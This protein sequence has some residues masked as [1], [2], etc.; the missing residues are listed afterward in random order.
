MR[1]LRQSAPGEQG[2]RAVSTEPGAGSVWDIR[3]TVTL[4]SDDVPGSLFSADEF[5][6]LCW[7]TGY[8]IIAMTVIQYGFG[9]SGNSGVVF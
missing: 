8:L 7:M 5:L 1:Y 6:W 9:S 2:I 4:P 3:I